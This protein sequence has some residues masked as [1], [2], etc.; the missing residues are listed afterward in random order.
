MISPEKKCGLLSCCIIIIPKDYMTH[1]LLHIYIV[2]CHV[3]LSNLTIYYDILIM[4]IGCKDFSREE[5]AYA[6]RAG[7]PMLIDAR[8][9]HVVSRNRTDAWRVV[10]WC[11]F[12]CYWRYSARIL[13]LGVLF[14]CCATQC[15]VVRQYIIMT[16]NIAFKIH[17]VRR[18]WVKMDRTCDD[19]T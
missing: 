7:E 16:S 11:I 1:S 13:W 6:Y 2:L 4:K 14:F 5:V 9:L 18:I 12:D 3:M 10:M 19:M 8:T 15:S 17:C